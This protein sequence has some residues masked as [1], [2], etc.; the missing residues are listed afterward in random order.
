[1]GKHATV[2]EVNLAPYI[3][4]PAA[5]LNKTHDSE[6]MRGSRPRTGSPPPGLGAA[7]GRPLRAAVASA[8]G[9]RADHLHLGVPV[10]PGGVGAGVAALEEVEQV[11]QVAPRRVRPAPTVLEI[12]LAEAPVE[13]RG[14]GD[15]KVPADR[16]C[17]MRQSRWPGRQTAC[18]AMRL[19][20]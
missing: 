13:R 12:V 4:L 20:V 18:L 11:D 2:A 3:G 15:G 14:V 16:P 5:S 7:M 8:R 9:P 10:E 19:A 17:R 1:M 6:R